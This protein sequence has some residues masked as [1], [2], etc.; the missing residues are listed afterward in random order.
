MNSAYNLISTSLDMAGNY[1]I[2]HNWNRLGSNLKLAGSFARY[3]FFA[4]HTV[5][6]G[7]FTSLENSV[8]SLA[9]TSTSLATGITAQSMTEKLF[10]SG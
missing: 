3:G 6:N 1:C 2:T 9:L 10:Y 4:Y 5:A 8:K 7:D